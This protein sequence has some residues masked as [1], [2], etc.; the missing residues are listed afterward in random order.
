MEENLANDAW[1]PLLS[2]LLSLYPSPHSLSSSLTSSSVSH[3]LTFS[4][5]LLILSFSFSV[6]LFH[7]HTLSFSPLSPSPQTVT[8]CFIRSRCWKLREIECNMPGVWEKKKTGPIEQ[9]VVRAKALIFCRL[10]TLGTSHRVQSGPGYFLWPGDCY[11]SIAT[12]YCL[13]W[14]CLFSASSG[15]L[16]KNGSFNCFFFT[17]DVDSTI[18][19]FWCHFY[20]GEQSFYVHQF[21]SSLHTLHH[22]QQTV[23]ADHPRVSP[24]ES[25]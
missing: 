12:G 21:F 3:S 8:L 22:S 15:G 14:I 1:V 5:L 10:R 19:T 23:M 18:S 11:I 25:D 9:I 4:I 7:S 16:R 20:L 24:F 2:H 13:P 6:S 17:V